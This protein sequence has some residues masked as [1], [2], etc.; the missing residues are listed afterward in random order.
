MDPRNQRCDDCRFRGILQWAMT[1]QG[2]AVLCLGCVAKLRSKGVSVV[3]G[4]KGP[5]YSRGRGRVHTW[6]VR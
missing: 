3:V 4:D 6:A 5:R 1:S 2:R